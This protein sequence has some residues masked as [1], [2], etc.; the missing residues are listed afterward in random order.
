V[1]DE[2]SEGLDA[3]TEA[4]LVVRLRD[5]LDTSGSGLILV[6]HRPA[7]AAL[8]EQTVPLG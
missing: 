6:S 1:L 2:P 3:E 7:M 5:W 8:A 4:L